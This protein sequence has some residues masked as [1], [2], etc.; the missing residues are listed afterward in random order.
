MPMSTAQLVHPIEAPAAA[1]PEPPE[2]R[3]WLVVLFTTLAALLTLMLVTSETGPGKLRDPHPV[4]THLVNGNPRASRP[5]LGF[6]YWPQLWQVIGFGGAA[7]LLFVYGRKSW[8]ERRMHN[9]LCITLA[10]GGMFVFDPLYNWL[11]YF[12]TDPRFLHIPHGALPWS[13]LAP[14]FEPVFFFPLYMLWLTGIALLSNTIWGKLRAREIRK[15]G[16]GSWMARHPIISLLIVCKLTTVIDFGG[17]RLGA[18]TDAFI[19]TQ[20]PGPL[21]NGGHTSQMQLLW[22]PILFPLTIMAT[23]LLFY[24]DAEGT[25]IHGRTARRLR[26]FR[27]FPRLTEVGVAWSILATSY[28]VCLLGMAAL[29]FTGQSD[30]LAQPW[31]YSD[32][33]VYDPDGLY[34]QAGAPGVK[35]G[36]SGNWHIVRPTLDH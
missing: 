10:A 1:P 19:F 33:K 20:A 35:R 17:F 4:V 3:R 16:P 18:L 31:P 24:R 15:R 13:D 32:T 30:S 29:R 27:R 12:P 34:R 21:L 9:G 36:G 7:I 25:T 23:S 11:G 22:E 28:I 14:T 5:F 2:S 6:D 26:S 8:R